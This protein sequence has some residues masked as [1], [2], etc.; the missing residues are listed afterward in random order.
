MMK[1]DY[2]LLEIYIS[3]VYHQQKSIEFIKY[4]FVCGAL[5]GVM[6]LLSLCIEYLYF[7][8]GLRYP[9]NNLL[10]LN[11]SNVKCCL[12]IFKFIKYI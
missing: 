1:Y 11:L 10:D 5:Y 3:F 7:N 6:Y 12:L 2:I 9:L 4:I 8:G